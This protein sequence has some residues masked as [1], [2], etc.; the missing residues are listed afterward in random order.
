MNLTAGST[1]GPY[2]IVE[3]IATSSTAT[4]YRA[5]DPGL[6]RDVV[7]KVLTPAFAEDPGFRER[8]EQE[9]IVVARLRHPNII[10]ILDYGED[11]GL[12]YLV[13]E[14]VDGGAVSDRTHEA[15]PVSDA[16][17]ILGPIASA[18]DYAHNAGLLHRNIKP[19]NIL[20]WHDGSPVLADFGITTVTSATMRMTQRNEAGGSPEYMAPEQ[21][22]GDPPPGAAADQYSLAV[23]AYELLTHRVPFSA[24]TPLEVLSAIISQPVPRPRTFL[25]SI[26][27]RV[28]EVL[29][30][31]LAKAPVDRYPSATQFV[32]ALAEAGRDTLPIAGAPATMVTL[33]RPTPG[34]IETVRTE[35]RRTPVGAWL[36]IG[37]AAI[38]LLLAATFFLM[39]PSDPAR[40]AAART[41]APVLMTPTSMT[42]AQ[43][44]PPPR[45]TVGISAVVPETTVATTRSIAV[46][47]TTPLVPA[48]IASPTAVIP[49]TAQ[50]PTASA[51]TAVAVAP[52]RFPTTGAAATKGATPTTGCTMMAFNL[53]DPAACALQESS[54]DPDSYLVGYLEGD[55]FIRK[56]HQDGVPI[57]SYVLSAASTYGDATIAVDAF[58]VNETNGRSILLGCRTTASGVHSAYL[59]A[60]SPAMGLFSLIKVVSDE[61]ESLVLSRP[62]PAIKRGQETNHIELSCVGNTITATANGV[63]LGSRQDTTLGNGRMVVGVTKTSAVS[64][65]SEVR[66]NSLKVAPR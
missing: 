13:T 26:S 36:G 40:S 20:M 63:E 24:P 42:T 9:A 19:A 49:L 3:Q 2:R 12:I 41:A 23:V 66:F 61:P 6:D 38:V 47:T 21:A 65:I 15:M 8:F 5:H 37:G 57:F 7:I 16:V 45:G 31:A 58:L 33:T 1:L 34:V 56:L 29:L 27:P 35:P 64:G 53:N 14:F 18:L 48:A 51:P 30:K 10:A 44:T 43:T 11:Q 39:R 25:P 46:N 60:V 17:K 55:Y 52:T 50:I 59:L 22:V 62:S 28:E 54:P 4:T 32:D